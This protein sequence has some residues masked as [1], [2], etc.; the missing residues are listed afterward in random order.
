MCGYAYSNPSLPNGSYTVTANAVWAIDWSING[1]TGSIPFYQSA[2]SQI[3]V[4][5]LQVLVR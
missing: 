5:E 3:P 4:G 1:A 2:S